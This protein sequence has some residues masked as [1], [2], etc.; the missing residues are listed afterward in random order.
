MGGPPFGPR[1]YLETQ[2]KLPLYRSGV[3]YTHRGIGVVLRYQA[4]PNRDRFRFACKQLM[5]KKSANVLLCAVGFYWLMVIH[6]QRWI[7]E[8]AYP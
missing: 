6:P 2:P 5:A 8:Y 4:S 3:N 7:A 1:V